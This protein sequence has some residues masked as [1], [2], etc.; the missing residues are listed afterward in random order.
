VCSPLTTYSRYALEE[1]RRVA[2]HVLA[3]PLCDV[4]GAADWWLRHAEL[5]R[6]VSLNNWPLSTNLYPATNGNRFRRPRCLLPVA[7]AAPLG[8][9]PLAG[10][11]TT[12]RLAACIDG[13]RFRPDSDPPGVPVSRY[14]SQATKHQH[15][16]RDLQLLRTTPLTQVGHD[17]L[18]DA[19]FE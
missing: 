12:C 16:R 10:L 11:C 5:D 1:T 8:M 13:S 19:D 6:A 9:V 7:Q 14:I 15:L 3:A 4:I 18:T 2:P 17:D